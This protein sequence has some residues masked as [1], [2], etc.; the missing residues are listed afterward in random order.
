MTQIV[1]PGVF[2]APEALRK[3][4]SD[5]AIAT[6]KYLEYKAKAAEWEK[7]RNQFRASIN[8]VTGGARIVKIGN[9]VVATSTPKDQFSG[10]R[11]AAEYPTLHEEYLRVHSVL[12]LDVEALRQDHPEIA[13]RFTVVTF[14]NKVA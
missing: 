3:M 5:E 14:T 12:E 7:Y 6:A 9:E 10:G 11:F 4:L 8:L 1:E 2:Q 13:D